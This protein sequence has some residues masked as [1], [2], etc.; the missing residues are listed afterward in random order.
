MRR[1]APAIAAIT[2]AA[3]ALSGCSQPAAEEGGPV[4]LTMWS[5]FTVGDRSAYEGL[6]KEF[7]ATHDDIQL[8]M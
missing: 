7:N 5:G 6:I 2:I 1:I 3:F 4:K 8:T